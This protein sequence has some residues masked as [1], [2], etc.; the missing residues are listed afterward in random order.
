LFSFKNVSTP[1]KF[2]QQE[3]IVFYIF[4]LDI[5]FINYASEPLVHCQHTKFWLYTYCVKMSNVSC[6]A[7]PDAELIEDH[8]AGDMIC[9][10]CGLVVGDR[11]VDVSSEWR[12]FSSDTNS[13]DPSRVGSPENNLMSGGGLA[14]S[15]AGGGSDESRS[16]S[17]LQKRQADQ[18]NLLFKQVQETK[19]LKG[20]NNDA[21]ASACLYIACRKDGV[22]RTF[23]EI[24]A[25]SKLSKKESRFCGNLNLPQYVQTAATHIARAA[26]ENDLVS[27]RSPVSIAAAAI[28]MA[29][30][31]SLEK[32]CAKGAVDE[33]T[34]CVKMS[35]GDLSMLERNLMPSRS[36]IDLRQCQ[37]I[38]SARDHGNVLRPALSKAVLRL[39]DFIVNDIVIENDGITYGYKDLCLNTN[40]FCYNNPQVAI[41]SQMFAEPNPY[42]NLSY[43]TAT[44]AN[45]RIYLGL[46]LGGVEL[47]PISG[48]IEQA[49]AWFLIYQLRFDGEFDNW[50]SSKWELE[51]ER[52]L[53]HYKDEMLQLTVFHSQTLDLELSKNSDYMMPK[54]SLMFMSLIIFATLCAVTFIWDQDGLPWVDWTRST[55]LLAFAGIVGA[56][57]GVASS[58]GLLSILGVSF[59]EVIAV[60]LD[61]TFLMTSS[62]FHT[63]RSAPVAERISEAMGD[64]AV[65]ITITVLTDVLSFGV[66]YFTSFPAVQLFCTYTCV[67]MIVTF[68]YQLTFLLGLLVLHARNEAR[69]KHCLMPVIKTYTVKETKSRNI[70]VRLFCTGSSSSNVKESCS[71]TAT[72]CDNGYIHRLSAEKPTGVGVGVEWDHCHGP[73]A[74]FKANAQEGTWISRG[75]RN[76]FAPFLMKPWTKA[77]IVLLYLIY[78]GTSI[79][80]CIG[81]K[82]GLEPV[83]LLVSDSYAINFYRDLERYFWHIGVQVQ[84]SFNR[85]GNLSDPTNRLQIY[86]IVQEFANSPHGMGEEGLEFWLYE[87]QQFLPKY[88]GLHVDDL[89]ERRFYEN[90]EAFLQFT[91]NR[92]FANDVLLDY[93]YDYDYDEESSSAFRLMIGIKKFATAL[94]QTETTTMFRQLAEKHSNYNITTFHYIWPFVDQYIEVLPNVLQE[95]YSGMA[96]MVLIALLLIPQP[97]CS[98]WVT[99]MIASID[100]GVVGY[101]TLWNLSM[102]CVSMITLIMSIGFSVDFSAHIAYAYT[103]SQ[104]NAPL[105]RIR[106]ALGSLA[107]PIIQGGLATILG[108]LVLSDVNSYMVKAFFKT[109]LLVILIGVVHGIVF[110]PVLL[111]ITD[112][113]IWRTL[114]TPKVS[115]DLHHDH[116]TNKRHSNPGLELPQESAL[117]KTSSKNCS[118]FTVTER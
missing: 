35:P 44:F 55:P 116:T 25:V 110:L 2:V 83:N 16:L 66:G 46:T 86:N 68:I 92:R 108:V 39:N 32:R 107:W 79:Y 117:P 14:T 87:F 103:V 84:A 75:F 20:K 43:P 6:P 61:N 27:G 40:N 17:N 7:H 97:L 34:I 113:K 112:F 42:G 82:E 67:A 29:S 36:V 33:W 99:L 31:A 4:F 106:F 22:P 8:R 100:I 70:L 95:V 26:V 49:K 115:T 62:L 85:P 37:V 64:A 63:K 101:M 23:K 12:S 94:D 89:D 15:I 9:M 30:Q 81:L 98:V 80:G 58:I 45:S 111:S 102:D 24:C 11:I 41:I 48:Q 60:R 91:E 76:Y 114:I 21:V 56:G 57:M 69:A 18:A 5:F 105:D 51:F 54:M 73:V 53:L 59:C 28:Y 72:N 90:L 78:L 96:C 74:E 88:N 10:E 13:K 65:S 93:D 19:A 50:L 38:V 3:I 52:A 1:L 118:I 104:D 47:D 71:T 109:V 77:G